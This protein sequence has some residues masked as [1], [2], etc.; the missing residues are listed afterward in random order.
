[1]SGE[2]AARTIT[3]MWNIGVGSFPIVVLSPASPPVTALQT[4]YQFSATS[5]LRCRHAHRRVHRARAGPGALALVLAGQSGRYAAELGTMRVTE[6][7]DAL[8]TLGRSPASHLVIPVCW[9][10]V[11]DSGAR[12][13]RQRVWCRGWVSVQAVLPVTDA[14]FT[15]G[16]RVSSPFDA[17]YSI[18]KAFRFAN[19]HHHLCYM[20]F[21]PSRALRASANP[22]PG[23][24]LELR[25]DSAACTRWPSCCSTNDRTSRRIQAVR[26]AG[27]LD[28]GT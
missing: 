28:G 22:R 13:H 9:P 18:I 24:G 10:G 2:L 21:T 12:G 27:D 6:Q 15:Y 4:G 26:D 20:G 17:Y 11:R 3:E 16:A 8:E 23:R 19:Y 1:V 5:P 25:H 7:I 14:D